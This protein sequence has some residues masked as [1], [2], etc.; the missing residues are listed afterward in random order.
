MNSFFHLENKRLTNV[1]VTA[2]YQGIKLE[3]KEY[4]HTVLDLLG[5][6]TAKVQYWKAPYKSQ[7]AVLQLLQDWHVSS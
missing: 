5:L 3:F 7:E 4:H 1:R 6:V 2:K